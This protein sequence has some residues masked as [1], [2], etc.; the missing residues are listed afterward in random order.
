MS[1]GN[2]TFKEKYKRVCPKSVN[3]V[4]SS[5]NKDGIPVKVLN[6]FKRSSIAKH[7]INNLTCAISY[8]LN[9]FKIFKHV[10]MFSIRL[11]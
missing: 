8:N 7:L 1:D 4:C 5:E 10:I 9:I 11:N 3:N 6:T 2:K